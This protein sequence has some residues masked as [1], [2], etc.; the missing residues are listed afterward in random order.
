MLTLSSLSPSHPSLPPRPLARTRRQAAHGQDRR[1][2]RRGLLGRRDDPRQGDRGRQQVRRLGPVPLVLQ[3]AQGDGHGR[4]GAARRARA[5]Q[6]RRRRRAEGPLAQGQGGVADRRQLL[7]P[8]PV[9]PARRQGLVVLHER[10]EAGRR[11]PRGGAAHLAG[12]EAGGRLGIDLGLA[13]RVHLGHERPRRAPPLDRH[14]RGHLG[15]ACRRRQAPRVDLGAAPG[16][17]ARE[18]D[19]TRRTDT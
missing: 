12:Q 17:S 11:H 5:A 8:G 3:Q 10:L 9:E 2:P 4:R 15:H 1:V 7:P 6:A 16:L 18:R 14:R 13:R 19:S